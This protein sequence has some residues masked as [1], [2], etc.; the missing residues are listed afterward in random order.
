MYDQSILE[1]FWSKV[2]KTDGCWEWTGAK[3]RDG[4]GNFWTGDNMISAHR[5]SYQLV[6]GSIP[7]GMFICHHCDNPGCVRVDHLF[8]GTPSDNIQDALIKGR[9]V[10]PDNHG[11]KS[12]HSK[13]MEND[14]Y[15]IRRL[16][17]LGIKQNLL[18]KLWR[19]GKPQV[20]RIVNRKHW[21]HI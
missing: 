16:H 2:K 10:F 5:F 11:E 3:F 19:I 17:S 8:M 4:Y 13:L 12:G 20:N 1:R 9:L 21:R 18:A 7:D 15:E 6:K 14:V